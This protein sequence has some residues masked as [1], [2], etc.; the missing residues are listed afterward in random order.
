MKNSKL[1]FAICCVIGALLAGCGGSSGSSSA[2][3]SPMISG[4]FSDSQVVG[5]QYTC[6][7]QSGTTGTGGSF[8][9]P[10]GST[11]TFAI[12]GITLCTA[13]AL[14]FMTPLSCEQ[15]KQNN[16]TIDVTNPAVVAETQFLMSASATLPS[17]GT[18]TFTASQLLAAQSLAQINF[19]TVTQANLLAAVQAISPLGGLATLFT[20][21]EA[22]AELAGTVDTA[23]AGTFSGTYV[24]SGAQGTGTWN[25]TISAQGIV[26]GTVTQTG[27]TGNVTIAG[28]LT[29]GT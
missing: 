6:G 14:S 11:V 24:G 19:A 8:S 21:A 5:M 15:F 18:L 4:V 27:T 29:S 23:I 16:P 7:T 13:P 12:G 10:V 17:T 9:C 25:L 3:S 28:A 22:E 2:G 26:A 20:P 1:L